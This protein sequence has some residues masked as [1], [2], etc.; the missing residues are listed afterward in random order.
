MTIANAVIIIVSIYFISWLFCISIHINFLAWLAKGVS[1]KAIAR[2][3]GY[4][5][6]V[7]GARERE[8]ESQW[9]ERIERGYREER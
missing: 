6:E 8:R 9:R 2:Q 3:E 5:G 4:G 7:E 1:A